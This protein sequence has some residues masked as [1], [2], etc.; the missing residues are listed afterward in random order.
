MVNCAAAT[1]RV[2]LS[3]PA[4]RGSPDPRPVPPVTDLPIRSEQRM[5]RRKM[6]YMHNNPCQPHWN[7]VEHPEDYVR[8]SARFYLLEEPAIIPLDN[9][10][11]LLA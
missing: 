5:I 3:I 7:L 9:A 1:V 2:S 10:N 4:Q 11:L 6:T 8:S